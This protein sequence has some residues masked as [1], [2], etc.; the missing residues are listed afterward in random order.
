MIIRDSGFII[1]QKKYSE[2]LILINI[3]SKNHG[4]VKGLSR[5]QKKKN[6]YYLKL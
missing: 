1:S 4:L 3:L 6:L 2:N 5:I